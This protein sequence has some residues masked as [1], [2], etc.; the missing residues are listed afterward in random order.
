MTVGAGRCVVRIVSARRRRLQ[1]RENLLQPYKPTWAASIDPEGRDA[2]DNWYGTYLTPEG[3]TLRSDIELAGYLREVQDWIIRPQ[4]KGI[5]DIAGVDAIGGFVKQYHVQPD[6]M[7]LVSYGM[8]FHDVIEALEEN[9]VSTGAGYIEHKGESYLV[10]AT[11]RSKSCTRSRA[12]RSWLPARFNIDPD[13][14]Q[15]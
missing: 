14:C 5:K 3:V 13:E 9:N 4:L 6:P 7:K 10:R 12:S 15:T 1:T 8:T 11:G 2:H